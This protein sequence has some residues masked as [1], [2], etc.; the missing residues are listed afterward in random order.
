M[1]EITVKTKDKEGKSHLFVITVLQEANST[2]INQGNYKTIRQDI[3]EVKDN[4]F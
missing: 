4:W 3:K 2:D 1:Q